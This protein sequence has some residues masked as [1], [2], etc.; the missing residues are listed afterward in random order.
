[1][2][3]MSPKEIKQWEKTRTKGRRSYLLTSIF[4][5]ALIPI[6]SSFIWYSLKG[7][8]TGK[9]EFNSIDYGETLFKSGIFAVFGYY[10]AKYYWRKA[11]ERYKAIIESVEVA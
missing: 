10:Q 7:L 2:K 8:W 6:V 9:Y 11:E 1:M 3:P 4:V 5:Y